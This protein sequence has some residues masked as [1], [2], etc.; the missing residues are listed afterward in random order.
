MDFD[1]SG[2][3]SRFG[4]GSSRV[5]KHQRDQ[6]WTQS[7]KPDEGGAPWSIPISR[8]V[9]NAHGSSG[10]IQT[11]GRLSSAGSCGGRRVSGNCIAKN[12]LVPS[13]LRLEDFAYHWFQQ[14]Q[15]M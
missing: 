6:D 7:G 1:R 2:G 4:A 14:S 13:S 9:Q 11:G 3:Q 5:S 15:A 8:A 12:S 10:K